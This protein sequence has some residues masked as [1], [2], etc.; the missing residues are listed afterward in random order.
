MLKCQ[1]CGT[2]TQIRR[3]SS[4]E[5]GTTIVEIYQCDCG[6]KIERILNISNTIYWS[7]TGTRLKIEK[8][9]KCSK[10]Y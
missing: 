3:I 1:N 2:T 10:P 7:P 9:K 5:V 6:A 4:T 8:N